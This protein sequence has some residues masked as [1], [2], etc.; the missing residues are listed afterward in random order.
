MAGLTDEQFVAA[1][2]DPTSDLNTVIELKRARKVARQNKKGKGKRSGL[3]DEDDDGD[4][5]SVTSIEPAPRGKGRGRVSRVATDSP[6]PDFGPGK[7][8]KRGAVGPSVDPSVDEDDVRPKV[9]SHWLQLCIRLGLMRICLQGNKKRKGNKGKAAAVYDDEEEEEEDD[10]NVIRRAMRDCYDAL[11]GVVDSDSGEYRIDLFRELVNRKMFADCACLSN[12]DP[13][14]AAT[15]IDC[16]RRSIDYQIIKKPISMKQIH[17]GIQTKYTSMDQ[18]KEDINQMFTNART[19][20]GSFGHALWL[21]VI[22]GLTMCRC[23]VSN[24]NRFLRLRP[25]RRVAAGLRRHI[26]P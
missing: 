24:R 18:F 21:H 3:D 19:Y 1:L 13:P 4:F 7:K 26:S 14:E 23:V 5:G 10:I 17:K 25:G 16:L 12:V 2:E 8:R 22:F 6:A 11:M 15:H 9:R 20:N